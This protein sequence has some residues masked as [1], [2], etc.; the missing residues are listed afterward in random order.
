MAGTIW[1]ERRRIAAGEDVFRRPG[2][3]G[4]GAIGAGDR[5]DE[6][7]AIG[8]QEAL[9]R[10]EILP[11]VRQADMFE[12]A[13]RDDAVELAGD[14]A[15]VDELELHLVGDAHRGGLVAGVFELFLR[16]GDAQHFGARDLVEEARHAAPAAADVED[17]LAGL[18]VQFR[19]DMGEFRLL[20]RLEAGLRRF[21]IGAAVLA[22]RDRGTG[23]RAGRRGRNGARR[24]ASTGGRSS[25]GRTTPRPGPGATGRSAPGC[26]AASAGSR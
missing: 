10:L 1:T 15:I 7:D 8:L 25:I 13:D 12:H 21:E 20:R 22:V 17:F 16:Q 24:C 9:H 14:A 5:V 11:E 4:A 23:H 26:R 3:G 2:V 19:R 6:G 18:E